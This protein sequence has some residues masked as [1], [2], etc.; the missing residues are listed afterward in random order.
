MWKMSQADSLKKHIKYLMIIAVLF[1]AYDLFIFFYPAILLIYLKHKQ[2]KKM[3]VSV[4]IMFIPQILIVLWFR[5]YD[6]IELKSENSGLYFDIITSYFKVDDFSN[7]FRI[8]AEVP[9]Y[10][11]SNYLDSN[12]LFLPLLFSVF[13]IWGLFKNILLNEIERS[14]LLFALIVFLITN[15]APYQFADVQLRG[16]W[17]ARLYQPIFIV[18]L[19]YIIRFSSQIFNNKSSQSKYCIAL[20]AACVCFNL[21]INIG[22]VFGSK[23]TQRAWYRFYMHSPQN[24]MT[25]NLKQFGV[26]LI[27]FQ[28]KKNGE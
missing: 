22:G 28:A 4:P 23:L 18:M 12:F 17:I 26:K 20:I 3:L 10:L 7:W 11:L 5:C 8:M 24:T 25:E 21:A 27:D 1:T 19:M 6:V 15:M 16:E 2:W 13:V 14:V 9:G